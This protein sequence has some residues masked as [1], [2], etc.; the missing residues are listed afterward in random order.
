[1]PR[2]HLYSRLRASAGKAFLQTKKAT[3]TDF[4]LVQA[5]IGYPLVTEAAGS[6]PLP[7][8]ALA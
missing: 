5:S 3:F 8:E 6:P 2:Y 4:G 7:A 1:M